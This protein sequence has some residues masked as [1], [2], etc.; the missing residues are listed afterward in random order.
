[1][2][3]KFRKPRKIIVYLP[4]GDFNIYYVLKLEDRCSDLLL[5]LCDGKIIKLSP[6]EWDVYSICRSHE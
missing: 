4:S 5:S 2:I 1:M 6:W 3:K